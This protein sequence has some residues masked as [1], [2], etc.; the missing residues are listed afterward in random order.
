LLTAREI[1]QRVNERHGIKP[2][3]LVRYDNG[4][5]ALEWAREF[6]EDRS[7][8]ILLTGSAGGGKSRHGLEK[9]NNY[10]QDYP[11]V[12]GLMMRKAR[13]WTNKSIVPFMKQ[14][15]QRGNPN[16]EIKK[17]ESR[18]E[19]RNGSTLFW[20]GMKD[21]DQRESMRSIGGD[22]GL[23]IALF[24]EANAFTEDDFNETLARMRSPAAPYRQLILQTNPDAPSHWINQ[25]LIIG[26]Q[27]KVYYSSA[28]DNPYNPP[29][30]VEFLNSLTG[31]LYERLVLGRWVQAEGVVYDNF[32][33][34]NVTDEAEYNPAWPVV[35]GVDDGYAAGAG[36][37][38][39]SYHPRVV[40]LCQITPQ[41]GINVF[42][43]YVK[44]NELSEKTLENILA[45]PY[46]KPEVAY[47]DSSAAELRSRI[48]Q[49]EIQTVS[50]THP[51]SEGIKN[52][53]RLICDGN[54]MRL[55]KV[56]P[57]CTETITE[58]QSYRYDINS[59]LVQAGEPKPL[60]EN[61][62]CMD[63]L[64]YICHKLRYT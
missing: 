3:Q 38:S 12:P 29:E 17:S 5:R 58:I 57:R 24:E 33:M 41:G 55:L 25:R 11:G 20:G 40:L 27:A 64:R 18:F 9:L 49:A 4:F 10:M 35:Y 7:P 60:K 14:T 42:Y 48:W 6:M 54:G 56:H 19:Y 46:P 47:V 52:V 53:R 15:V 34:E 30:Y 32:T 45:L 36:K 21:D 22:G 62:H 23:G 43:E 37:G 63:A 44:T 8:I 61:D 50:A 26:G 28:K 51:V 59:H 16:V 1:R 13:E 39:S 31:I 2:R